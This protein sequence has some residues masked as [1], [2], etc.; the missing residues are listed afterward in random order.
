VKTVELDPG[1]RMLAVHTEASPVDESRLEAWLGDALAAGRIVALRL[2]RVADGRAKP[3]TVAVLGADELDATL[4]T[5]EEGFAFAVEVTDATLRLGDPT[6]GAAISLDGPAPGAYWAGLYPVSPD[7]PIGDFALVFLPRDSQLSERIVWSEVPDLDSARR[8]PGDMPS[9][10]PV[11]SFDDDLGD[12]DAADFM[13]S[14][15]AGRGRAR[16]EPRQAGEPVS[17]MMKGLQA[18]VDAELLE[19]VEPSGLSPLAD[20]L[21]DDASED[22]FVMRHLGAWLVEQD[23]VDDVFGEDAEIEAILLAHA[24]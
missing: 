7:E 23:E 13:R 1:V 10:I 11:P 24:K 22:P 8:T 9:P 6:T 16:G 18:L 17:P 14:L 2:G 20:R 3:W 19:L 4:A 21:E 15:F 12:M 5:L